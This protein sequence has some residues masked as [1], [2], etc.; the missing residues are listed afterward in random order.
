MSRILYEHPLNE[1]IRSYL[2]LEH[3]FGQVTCA[4]QLDIQ[5]GYSVLFTALFAIL[6][7]LDRND[8]RGDLIKDLEKLEQNLVIWSQ[9]PDVDTSALEENLRRTVSLVNR[10]RSANTPWS[11]LKDDKLLSGVRQRFAI[12]GGSA[13][14]D[15]PQLQFFLHQPQKTS[16]EQINAWLVTLEQLKDA[17]ALILVF[18]RQ[19]SHFECIETESGFYQ[20]SGEGLLLLRIQVDENAQY[21]PTVSGNRFR[22]SIRFMLPCEQSG[23]RYSN[24]ATKF[25]LAKC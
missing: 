24:L 12:Q 11:K 5:Q 23:R 20:D 3:L 13:S 19:R 21:Y 17:V 10:L 8:I 15:L 1:R 22:Y 7:S 9:R 18:I 2:K 25:Y 16:E 6:D 14:F 4:Q